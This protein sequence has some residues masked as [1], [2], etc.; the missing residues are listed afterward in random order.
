MHKKIVFVFSREFPPKKATERYLYYCYFR[1]RGYDP[2][3]FCAKSLCDDPNVIAGGSESKSLVIRE[4]VLCINV[5]KYMIK[6]RK[7]IEVMYFINLLLLCQPA[8]LLSRLLGFETIFDIRTGP[9]TDNKVKYSMLRFM[10]ILSLSLAQKIV[11]IDIKMLENVYGQLFIKKSVELTE[12]FMPHVSPVTGERQ[13]PFRFIL[14]TT[15]GRLRR[16]E[17]ICRAFKGLPEHHLYLYGDGDNFEDLKAE[18]GEEPNIHFMGYVP[19]E[20]VIQAMPSFDYGIS[21]IPRT[22]FYEYQPP[23]KTIEYLGAGLPVIATGTHGNRIY[24][25][26]SNGIIIEDNEAE[27]RSA[28]QKIV[29]IP[30]DRQKIHEDMLRFRWDNIF[31][32]AFSEVGLVG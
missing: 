4:L 30:Y 21:Y 25:N 28:I 7:E 17:E 31:D 24:V 2:K 32:K 6:H 13:K 9:I 12:G 23:L 22:H 5:M 11:T 8:I 1:D 14:P 18:F 10:D 20:E 19:Y 3:M 15:L 26:E 16:I 27:L 29:T